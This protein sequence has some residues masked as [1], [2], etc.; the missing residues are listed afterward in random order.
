MRSAEIGHHFAG[1]GN[2][3]W[4]LLFDAGLVPEP[5]S[6][7]DDVRLPEWGYGLTNIVARATPSMAGLDAAEYGA[8]AARLRRLVRRHRPAGVVLVGVTVYR[9][10]YPAR[11]GPVAL[12]V[13]V[14]E[15]EGATV[16]VVPNPSG[17]NAHYRYQD[18][19]AAYARLRRALSVERPHDKLWI[20]RRESNGLP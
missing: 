4:R 8:G 12:G 18:M 15:L 13:S 7:E 19:R 6:F 10:L 9:A 2:R 14:E 1:R 17:R 3:F 11:K 5:L 16:L 20:P